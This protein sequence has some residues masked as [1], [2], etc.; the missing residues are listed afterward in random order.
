MERAHADTSDLAPS[1]LHAVGEFNLAMLGGLL[2]GH[3]CAAKAAGRTA[4]VLGHASRVA[5]AR[6]EGNFGGYSCLASEINRS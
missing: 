6:D 1:T 3:G 2:C 5:K 4:L